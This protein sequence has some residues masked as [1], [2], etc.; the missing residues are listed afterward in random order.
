MIE[1]IVHVHVYVHLHSTIVSIYAI[2]IFVIV[3][4]YHNYCGIVG[5]LDYERDTHVHTYIDKIR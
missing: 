2:C 4:D 3:V 1:F 5:S